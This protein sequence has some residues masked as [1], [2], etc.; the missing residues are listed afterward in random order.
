MNA[1]TKLRSQI[2]QGLSRAAQVNPN[3]IATICED[4]ARSWSQV[5]ERVRKLAG[6]LQG[7]GLRAGD[8][9][10]ILSMNSDRF[11]ELYYAIWW[12]GGVATPMNMR[13]AP[14]EID[15]RLHDSG[16]RFL[17]IDS[18]HV[19]LFTQLGPV[20]DDLERVVLMDGE[21][22]D[23]PTLEKLLATAEPVDDAGRAGDDLALIIYTGGS[24]GR[25][26]GVMLSHDNLCA[27]AMSALQTIGYDETSVYLHAG[28]MSHLADGMSTFGLTLAAGT[29][30]FLPRFTVDACLAL[31]EKHRVTHVCL[32]PTMVEMIVAGAEKGQRDV[33][34]LVQI[35][36]GSSPMPEGTLRRAVALWPDILF[37]HGYGMTELSP[38]ITMLPLRWR[39]PSVG[40]D[41]LKSCGKAVPNLEVRIVDPD[42]REP[43]AGTVG[44]LIC[45]GPTVMLGYWNMPEATAKAIRNGWMH[46]EDAAYM[47]AEGFVYIVDRLKDMII[48]GGENIYSTEVEN[49]ISRVPGVSQVAVIGIPHPLWG[50]AVHAV[51][52]M[53]PGASPVS[54]AEIIAFCK[55]EIASYKCPKTVVVQRDLLPLT[56][57]GKI[58][59]K[60]LRAIHGA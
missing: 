23:M 3:G 47:D 36:F 59:K 34:S 10:G 7:M 44:E 31:I 6:A 27:N 40:G 29:H 9:V 56:S 46:T 8:R 37:L 26:K 39:R 49:V 28:P 51:V 22:D 17:F 20:K 14:A 2:S 57:A 42:G 52:S 58:D 53:A 15:Y 4:R 25:A 24:T 50:E 45:R 48:S 38:L 32:V 54:E 41:R 60:A 21:Q 43:P 5:L 33:T 35:Q 16:A 11:F 18:E 30:V 55:A 1:E 13:L 19:P 12:A